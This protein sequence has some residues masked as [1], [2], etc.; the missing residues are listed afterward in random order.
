MSKQEAEQLIAK[1]FDEY[2]SVTLL[3]SQ[4]NE[5]LKNGYF[6]LSKSRMSMGLKSLGQLQYPQNIKPGFMLK[7][8]HDDQDAL[9]TDIY[10]V[11]T[12]PAPKEET[13]YTIVESD[14]EDD[15]KDP[16]QQYSRSGGSSNGNGGKQQ[17]QQQKKISNNNDVSSSSSSSPSKQKSEQHT[18]NNSGNTSTRRRNVGKGEEVDTSSSSTSTSTST[19]TGTST[20]QSMS[21]IEKL[22]QSSTITESLTSNGSSRHEDRSDGDFDDYSSDESDS[23]ND[24]QRM[25]SMTNK[26]KREKQKTLKKDPIYWFG[27][28]TPATLKQSQTQFK[29]AI[30]LSI[31]ISNKLA[32][33]EEI[34]KRYLAIEHK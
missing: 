25:V 24:N 11:Q 17:Q 3:R 30:N 18:N 31:E 27:Y 33:M 10:Q 12:P 1:Y 34:Q 7:G 15:Q 8:V 21:R 32:R 13:I 22:L 14:E 6:M 9:E 16:F 28:L 5:T 4:L 2:Q 19:S 26:V 29:Q 20:S 23:D